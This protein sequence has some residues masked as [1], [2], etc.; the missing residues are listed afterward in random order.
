M[1]LRECQKIMDVGGGHGGLIHLDSGK[2]SRHDR[3]L[4]DS[5]Q[6]IEGAKPKIE[7][8]VSPIAAKQSVA[9]LSIRPSGA[10]TII[11]KWIIHDWNDEQSVAILKNCHRAFARERQTDSG[12]SRRAGD[13][14]T[15]L[16]QVHR[17]QHAG[18]DRRPRTH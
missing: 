4:F 12:R 1:I 17:S 13:E 14:R 15:T 9:F 6:V 11:L 3:I 8:P 7:L 10:D 18:N 5:P 16:Q 2:E